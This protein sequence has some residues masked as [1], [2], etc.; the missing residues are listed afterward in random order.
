MRGRGTHRL[1][2]PLHQCIQPH[3]VQQRL[4][5][6]R[7][8]HR[9]PAR[10]VLVQVA[11]L[12]LVLQVVESG[13]ELIGD[14][15]SQD[16]AVLPCVLLVDGGKLGAGVAAD[17]GLDVLDVGLVEK[18]GLSVL[19]HHVLDVLVVLQSQTGEHFLR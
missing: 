11:D 8:Q 4:W 7:R 12:E 17:E 19:E 14:P 2:Q 6:R 10:L 9:L 16:L 13:S 5:E 3:K 15:G 18:G 1:W